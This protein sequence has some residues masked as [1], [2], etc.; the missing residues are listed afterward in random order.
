MTDPEIE[1]VLAAYTAFARGDAAGATAAMDPAVEWTEP[2]SFPLSGRRV[3][4]AAVAEYLAAARAGWKHL[5][6]EPTATRVGPEIVVVHRLQGI[7]LDG[8]PHEAE[9]TD[10]FRFGADGKVVR[11][12]AYELPEEAFAAAALGRRLSRGLGVQ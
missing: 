6:S 8:T 3:G 10:V 9:A 11:M 7:L 1:A 5:T 2:L 4:P 12:R